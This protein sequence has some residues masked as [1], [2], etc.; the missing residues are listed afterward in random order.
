LTQF[1][2]ELRDAV[3]L[4]WIGVAES[5]HKLLFFLKLAPLRIDEDFHSRTG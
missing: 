4:D 5:W 3:T 2:Q 1:S